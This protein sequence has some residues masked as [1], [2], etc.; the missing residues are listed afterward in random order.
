MA[1]FSISTI[2]ASVLWRQNVTSTL[3][4]LPTG[5]LGRAQ[6]RPYL[7]KIVW[8]EFSRGS[9]VTL[10]FE[11]FSDREASA[12]S[13]KKKGYDPTPKIRQRPRGV[14]KEKKDSILRKLVPLMPH[15]QRSFWEDLPVSLKCKD[16][17]T[18]LVW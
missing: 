16:L 3:W 15:N 6:P 4:R 2:S 14:A 13:F 17:A 1:R 12:C 8:A 18:A 11:N 5:N 9:P 10:F 7:S